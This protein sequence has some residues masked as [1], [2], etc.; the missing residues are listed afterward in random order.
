VEALLM[1]YLFFFRVTKIG[2]LYDSY[3]GTLWAFDGYASTIL[4]L[5]CDP[6]D[7]ASVCGAQELF[8]TSAL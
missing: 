7:G 1:V 3:F 4:Q 6:C 8:Y 5:S 2:G